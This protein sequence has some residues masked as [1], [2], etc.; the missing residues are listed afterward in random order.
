MGVPLWSWGLVV[1]VLL[2]A[3]V[4]TGEPQP[5]E[6]EKLGTAHQDGWLPPEPDAKA[7]DW[8]Q[9]DTHEW[10]KGKIDLIQDDNIQF[11]SDKLDDLEFEWD[12][13]IRLVTAKEHTFRFTACH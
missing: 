13:I 4:A 8:I 3:T 7:Y 1:P 6:P 5:P 2:V 10:L 12:D 9:L 11:D